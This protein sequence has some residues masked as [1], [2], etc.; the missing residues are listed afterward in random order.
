MKSIAIIPARGGSKR[1]PR[2]NIKPFCGKPI[3]VYSIEAALKSGL[4]DEVMVSTDDEE[5]AEIARAAGASVPFMRS[6]E[7]AND[8]A[9]IREVLVEV[10]SEYQKR[11]REFDTV[12]C[13]FP[14][15]PFITAAK[16]EQGM[17][18]LVSHPEADMVCPVTKY[19]YPPQRS[20]I[21]DEDGFLK[22]QYPEFYR[23]RTQDLPPVYH[24]I[25][26]FY[27]YRTEALLSGKPT[28]VSTPIF[29]P[30]EEVQDI[31]SEF[32]WAFAEF[33]YGRFTANEE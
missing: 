4:F 6:A 32:D 16:L 7:T 23:C 1:I 8:H 11:G 15:A 25:G 33:K 29:V 14:C 19:P 20:M 5:I 3:M 27:F 22:Y 17:E 9:I 18:A 2:K 28:F 30:E 24:E 13:L 31:D 12:A 26:A 10:L 21:L